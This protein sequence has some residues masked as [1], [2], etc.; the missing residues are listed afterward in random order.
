MS[1]GY[2]LD[3]LARRLGAEVVGDATLNIRRLA[4][5]AT[6]TDGDLSFLTNPR[7]REQ[8]L[9]SA[10]S[11]LLVDRGVEL[12]GRTLLVVSEPYLA[13]AE[14]LDLLYPPVVQPIGV[15]E[16]ARVASSAQLSEGVYVAPFAVIGADARL[17]SG[18]KVGAGAVVGDRCR[19][20]TG[21]ELMP[22]VV[23][24]PDTEVGR[25][26]LIHA[27]A[28]IGADGFGFATSS[29][30]HRKLRQVGRVRIE[31]GVEIG[32]NSCVDRAMLG[33]TVIGQG[34]KL[35]DLVMVA[36]GVQLGEGALLAAQAGIAGSAV[37]GDHLTLAG[38]SGVAGHLALGSRVTV[39]AKS[40]V[41]HD[42]PDSAFV[43]GVPAVDHRVWKRAQ[44]AARRAPE[45]RRQMT[46]L[47]SR[48]A[49]LESKLGGGA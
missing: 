34:S 15:D 27:G 21:T 9:R 26:C 14:L 30:R 38:Q 40:A 42:Q 20:G 23:L 33:E 43:A 13:L 5:L 29:G 16:Q 31:D 47:E 7:Y 24:Y 45:L 18:V 11:A 46:R 48:I 17:A 2:R 44:A 3:E 8:A 37:I 6:A 28:V 32:A 12:P 19:L 10:A 41:F 49:A 4:T 36:H 1:N 22:R 25:D 39:A 35:D